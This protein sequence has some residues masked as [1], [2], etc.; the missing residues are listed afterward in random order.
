MTLIAN[1]LCTET[2][3]Q[4]LFSVYGVTAHADHD[5]DGVSDSGVVDDCINQAT[6]EIRFYLWKNYSDAA[7]TTSTLVNRWAT[8]LAVYFLCLRRGNPVPDS[9]LAEFQRIMELLA[10]GQPI[11][12]L[13]LRGDL[14]PT[15][16]N[17]EIDRRYYRNKIRVTRP[18]ST[19]AAT[20]LTQ[21]EATEVPY[22]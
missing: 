9:L 10:S 14:R 13:P 2:E 12:N 5:A 19:D 4:R 7:L 22:E 11:P 20:T 8:T 21:H 18:N 16:S 3:M 17:V 15:M 1:T 6:E